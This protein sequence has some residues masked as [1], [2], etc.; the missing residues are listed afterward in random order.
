MARGDVGHLCHSFFRDATGMVHFKESYLEQSHQWCEN[1]L[2]WFCQLHIPRILVDNTHTRHWEYAAA[3]RIATHHRYRT[4]QHVCTGT[5][6]NTSG[7]PDSLVATMRT[8]F[9]DDK[10]L[11]HYLIDNKELTTSC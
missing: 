5:W 11:P 7:V 2:Y 1:A 8:R 9:E 10:L 4:F 3:V 6:Q